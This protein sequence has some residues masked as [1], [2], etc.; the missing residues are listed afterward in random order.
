MRKASPASARKDKEK[1]P[2]FSTAPENWSRAVFE[3]VRLSG[4]GVGGAG[5]PV[6]RVAISH[7]TMRRLRLAGVCV[8]VC[9]CVRER[10]RERE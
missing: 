10:E 9:V 6:P 7:G 2:P 3:H 4:K 5:G 1:T 8:C